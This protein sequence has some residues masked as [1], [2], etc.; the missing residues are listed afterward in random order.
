MTFTVVVICECSYKFLLERE[1]FL[2]LSVTCEKPKY[3]HMKVFCKGAQGI[4]NGYKKQIRYK[5]CQLEILTEKITARGIFFKLFYIFCF[6]EQKILCLL[7][8]E[9]DT[10]LQF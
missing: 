3:Y 9:K 4:V 10:V 7:L 5:A 6:S 8:E 1:F 2:K